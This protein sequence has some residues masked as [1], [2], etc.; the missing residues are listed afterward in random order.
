[1][2]GAPV[3]EGTARRGGGR[4]KWAA[5]VASRYGG[6]GARSP[7][8]TLKPQQEAR[9]LIRPVQ[10]SAR[11][12]NSGVI[13]SVSPSEVRERVHGADHHQKA[14][15]GCCTAELAGILMRVT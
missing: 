10:R 1:M 11:R 13:P 12:T 15:Q 2:P 3:N 8:L 14:S 6:L 4:L 9:P 5:A 7:S